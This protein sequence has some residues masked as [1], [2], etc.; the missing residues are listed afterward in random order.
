MKIEINLNNKNV[1]NEFNGQKI[2]ESLDNYIMNELKHKPLKNE[3]TLILTGNEKEKIGKV[4]QEYYQEKYIFLKRIDN[5]DNYIRLVLFMIGVIAILISE[6]FKNL[7]SE[8]FLIAGWVVIWEVV[9]DV[10]FNELKRKRE[11]NI[12]KALAN[13]KIK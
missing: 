6:Q 3:I 11:S 4:I 13:C 12:Y 7:L 8:I 10:L 1:L 9:Y 5:M 2:S